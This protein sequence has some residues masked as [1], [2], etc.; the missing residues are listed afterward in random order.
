MLALG[1]FV[2][3][4]EEKRRAFARLTTLSRVSPNC[5]DK[6]G[7]CVTPVGQLGKTN[8]HIGFRVGSGHKLR[9]QTTRQTGLDKGKAAE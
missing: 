2:W 7:W 4:R 6:H 8:W 3:Q 5:F 9:P 1:F